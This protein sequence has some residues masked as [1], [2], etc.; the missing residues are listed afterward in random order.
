MTGKRVE[1]QVYD[2]LRVA[3]AEGEINLGGQK[4][5]TVLLA[6]VLANG[7][8]VSSDRLIEIVWGSRPPAKPQLTLRSYISHLRR[9]LE[10]D[11]QPGNRS[12]LLITRAPGYAIDI[13]QLDVDIHQFVEHTRHA[14][15]LDSGLP[16]EDILAATGRAFSNWP[17][18]GAAPVAQAIR[19]LDDFPEDAAK[20]TELHLAL[21]IRHYQ[22]AIDAGKGNEAIASLEAACLEHPTSDQLVGLHMLAL[23]RA[24]R[25]T[26]ALARFQHARTT[27]LEEFGL[28]PSPLL[29][30]LEQQILSNDP[31]LLAEAD[32]TSPAPFE[33][34]AGDAPAGRGAALE[35]LIRCLPGRDQ[36]ELGGVIT[37]PAG[38]GKSTLLAALAGRADEEGIDVAWGRCVDTTSKATLRPWQTV[39]RDLLERTTPSLRD[40]VFGPQAGDLARIVPELTGFYDVDAVKPS[41]EVSDA[42]TRT[43]RRFAAARPLLICLEDLHWSDDE[44]LVVLNH[45]LSAGDVGDLSIVA[46]WRDTDVA[47]EATRERPAR[48]RLLADA[49][50]AAGS[51]RV[52]LEGLTDADVA[53]VFRAI[54]SDE[55]DQSAIHRLTK[56]TGGNP[57]F[58]T[59]LIR[60][61]RDRD[62]VPT[63][64]IREV[65]LRRLDTLPPPAGHVLAAAALCHPSIDESLMREL[66]GYGQDEFD[67]CVEAA[68]AARIVED[69]P[70]ELGRYRFSHD[71]LAE[72]LAATLSHRKRSHLHARIGVL[73]EK[74]SAP[75]A[76]I[77]HHYLLGRSA[78]ASLEAARFAHAAGTEAAEL[79]D[80]AGALQLFDS[81]LEALDDGPDAPARRIDITIDRAQ[82]LKFLSKHVESQQTSLRAVDLAASA[83]ELDLL[84]VA[85]MVY[86]GTARI[87]HSGRSTEWL[88][89]WSPPDESMAV[90]ERALGLMDDDHRW[91]PI[92][93]LALSAQMFAPHHDQDRAVALA[94]TAIGLLR[95]RD[96]LEPLCEGLVSVAQTHTRTLPADERKAMLEEADSIAERIDTPRLQVRARKALVGVALD[97]G[98]L[99]QARHHVAF[100]V[101]AGRSVD[102][103][104]V[105]IQAD[106][107]EISLELLAG[108][109]DVARERVSQGFRTY[110]RFGDAVMDTFGMQYFTLARAAGD[111]EPIIGAIRSR[112]TAYDGPA[113]AAPLAAL[114]ARSGDLAGARAVIDRFTVTDITWGGEGVL[115]YM[116]QAYFADAVADLALTQ[117]DLRHVI[118]PLIEAL[119]PA[120]DRMVALVGG[121]D[122]PS[123]G[124]LHVGRLLTAAGD[125]D[126]ASKVLT[127]AIARLGDIEARPALLWTTLAVAENAAAAGDSTAGAEAMTAATELADK[128]GMQWAV[129]WEND[130]MQRLLN[131]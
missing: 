98:D 7:A 106:S 97:E 26:D 80:Y 1:V 82:V 126:E 110:A 85:A 31:A 8:A 11:S 125:T 114:L 76:V 70:H 89:Y 63:D 15:S 66:L 51:C 111:F 118:P 68:V 127:R 124:G 40:D 33:R 24:G 57:L 115:Q 87:D 37:G 128:M 3:S 44:S 103:P 17:D 60:S 94:R 117:P 93:L 12:Q 54:R 59:E 100:G 55:P 29:I 39:L 25:V 28:D 53:E 22:A 119:E 61:G 20:V 21:S 64:T 107:L 112:L 67:V 102:D 23:Y 90:L 14:L 10:P 91:R 122:Y 56:H 95:T 123:I 36:T 129:T 49:G 41:G 108:N 43:L 77:A 34:P 86:V 38:I 84:I 62:M 46:T 5:Q 74:Q 19:T 81:A 45:L 99:G 6:L 32:A 104:F 130:R 35:T 96:A 65:V 69:N 73:L 48:T 72:T 131:R 101:A 120:V 30:E 13:D 121:T 27:M 42:I 47:A 79:G 83:G 113:Y 78:G 105:A 75:I 50:R 109:F 92:V 16:P 88:G 71:L 9:K 52:T 18:E 58:V 116:T 2:H 4:Q